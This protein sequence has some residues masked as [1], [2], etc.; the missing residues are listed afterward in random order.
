MKSAVVLLA[1]L[2]AFTAY[3]V[4]LPLPSTVSE[5][6]RLMLLDASFRAAQQ[7][8]RKPAPGGGVGGCPQLSP[9]FSSPPF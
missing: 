1:G 3:Y 2:F 8:V 6:W 7:T 4:Y 5:P 9:F